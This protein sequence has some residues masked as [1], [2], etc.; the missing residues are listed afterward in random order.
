M[1]LLIV[2]LS[3]NHLRGITLHSI[4]N[5]SNLRVLYFY[6]FILME[7]GNIVKFDSFNL[8][9]QHSFSVYE[10]LERGSYLEQRSS[11]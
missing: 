9:V 6:D 2:S 3:K 1:S 8:H 11:R 4:S 7:I 10:Y 5:L